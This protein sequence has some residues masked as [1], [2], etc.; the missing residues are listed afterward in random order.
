MGFASL[1]GYLPRYL[2]GCT[3]QYVNCHESSVLLSLLRLLCTSISLSP[4]YLKSS[5]PCYPPFLS[6][7]LW[8][9]IYPTLKAPSQ[10]HLD[11]CTQHEFLERF[12]ERDSCI[13]TC[14]HTELQQLDSNP[15]V[16]QMVLLE[17][18]RQL[19]QKSWLWKKDR[20]GRGQLAGWEEVREGRRDR[21]TRM[22]YIQ[23]QNCQRTDLIKMVKP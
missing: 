4:S 17:L 3:F 11:F 9:T 23:V 16:K 18:S 7:Y 19:S 8:L 21:R 12:W 15:V 20:Q 5:T 1:P 14:S 22:N 10:R 2:P 6:C 13:S